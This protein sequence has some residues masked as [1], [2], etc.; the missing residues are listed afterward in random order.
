M[1]LPV[2]T[3]ALTPVAAQ[4]VVLQPGDFNEDLGID[5][6]YH[7]QENVVVS[8][9]LPFNPSAGSWDFSSYG[10]GA[11]VRVQVVPKAGTPYASNYPMATTCAIQEIPGTDT[12]YFYQHVGATGVTVD[13][14]GVNSLGITIIGDYQPDWVPFPLPMQVGDGG[15]QT[16]QYSYNVLFI[17]VTITEVRAWDVAAEGTVRVPGVPYDMPCLVLHEFVSVTDSLGVIN[18]NYHLYSWLA[19]GGFAGANGLV[20]LQSQN[21]DGPSFTNCRNAFFLGDHNLSPE[22]AAPMLGV[23]SHDLSQSLGGSVTFSL[24]AGPAFAGRDYQLLGGMS[25]ASP[26]TPL[27][28]GGHLPVTFDAVSSRILSLSGTPTFQDFAGTLDAAG[29]A[30]AVLNA[31]A[32]MPASLLGTHLDFAFTTLSP[33]D[34]QSHSVW[35][36]V[37][38]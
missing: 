20:A 31:P 35:V 11:D 26:G 15:V 2:L 29:Q 18:D 23:D 25:G 6:H 38:P 17:T 4:S 9:A 10:S 37:G 1:P 14:F 21:G 28:G 33:F 7:Q 3:L 27:A 19:P 8:P 16:V 34:F 12:S 24:D 36:E 32:P 22:A 30:T 5:A 13:G